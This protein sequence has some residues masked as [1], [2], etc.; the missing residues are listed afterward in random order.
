MRIAFFGASK[1]GYECCK[2]LLEAGHNIV[3]AYTI[4][5]TFSI[6]YSS[7][8][9]RTTVT[10]SLYV[11]FGQL[12]DQYNIPVEVISTKMS[13]Y[14][15]NFSAYQVDFILAIGWYYMI[16]SSMIKQ[17]TKGAAGIHGSLLPKYRGNAP[18]VWA[19]I[20]G[21]TETGISF[22]YFDDGVDTGDIIAQSE[23]AI[24]PDDTI[25]HILERAEIAS[26]K[27]LLE[28][29][30]KIADGSAPRLVQDHSKATS[31]PKRTP[32][33]GLIDWTW[34]PKQI[35]DFIRAQTAPYPGAFTIIGGKKVTI[36]SADIVG[37][38]L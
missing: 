1:L 10:N 32:Q 13:D 29:V 6:K 30:P 11:D 24:G 8:A 18:F 12:K 23:I 26:K 19:I 5:E 9:Q 34:V 20:N 37:Y 4:P 2:A 27:I 38:E 33:D 15:D 35:K 3:V 28:Y 16:P 21:E 22:F 31:Y 25:A 7:D 17:A 14:V 36:W